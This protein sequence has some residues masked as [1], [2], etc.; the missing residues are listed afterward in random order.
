MNVRERIL[1][2]KLL[3]KQGNNPYYFQKL[4]IDIQI[5]KI[6]D[7]KSTKNLLSKGR[8]K[9]VILVQKQY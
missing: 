8:V 1:L 6:R 4:G 3:K 7:N 9:W 2:L 5:N